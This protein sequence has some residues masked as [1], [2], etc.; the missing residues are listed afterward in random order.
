M[1]ILIKLGC[2][3]RL[4]DFEQTLNGGRLF[5]VFEFAY[6][7][8]ACCKVNTT[9]RNVIRLLVDFFSEFG[10]DKHKCVS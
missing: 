5:Q 9:L 8:Q 10:E 3:R 7:I 4:M 6:S 2:Q 1:Y